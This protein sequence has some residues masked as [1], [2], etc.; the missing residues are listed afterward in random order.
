MQA[1]R[2]L[3]RQQ[4]KCVTA[5]RDKETEDE[6]R[7]LNAE[8]LCQLYHS[9]HA[10]FIVNDRVD[11]AIAFDAVRSYPV[12]EGI[13]SREWGIGNGESGVGTYS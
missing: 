6:T 5:D 1:S 13:G 4:P 8:K 3:P 2:L 12:K 11:L 9:Y 10:L 7:L